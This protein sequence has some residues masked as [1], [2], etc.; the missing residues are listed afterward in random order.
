MLIVYRMLGLCILSGTVPRA[1]VA[2]SWRFSILTSRYVA[3]FNTGSICLRQSSFL[4]L[5]EPLRIYRLEPG[6]YKDRQLQK[7]VVFIKIDLMLVA[8]WIKG[9]FTKDQPQVGSNNVKS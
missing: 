3:F 2:C 4:S 8:R 9:G 6:Q 7:K 5:F 1:L